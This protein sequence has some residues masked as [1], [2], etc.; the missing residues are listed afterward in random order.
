MK[1]TL[2]LLTALAAA[3]TFSTACTRF[4]SSSEVLL[5]TTPSPTASAPSAPAPPPA[6][7][8]SSGSYAGTWTSIANSIPSG[9]SCTNFQWQVTNATSNSMA[10]S[11]SATCAGNIAVVGTASGRLEGTS[12]PLVVGGTATYAGT[13][14]CDFSFS[15]TGV[16]ENND[17][18]TIP[19]TGT[20]CGTAVSG[21]ERLHRPAPAAAPEPPTPPPTPAPA[22]PLFGCGGVAEHQK[23]VE[24][25]WDHIH[26]TDNNSAFEVT[27]RVAWALRGE[28]AGLLIKNGGDN[29]T[30]WQ[31][32]LFSSSRIA[33]PDGRLVKV[34]SD[35]GPGGANGAS[36]QD[37][38]DYVDPGLY[39]P[40]MDPNLP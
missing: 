18:L 14:S 11:F 1:R 31:G 12:V 27:K 10:G 34:I 19:Y 21:T 2:L 13:I 28:G 29:I 7:P 20:V 25:I 39:V 16:I 22:D 15:G 30:A 24:C 9:S 23:L 6:P 40:A 17:T 4:E 33:Y 35:A 3:S 5:P 8:A 26:P 36:W 32:Y 38:G 37:N